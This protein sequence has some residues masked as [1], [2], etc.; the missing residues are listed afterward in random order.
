MLCHILQSLCTITKIKDGRNEVDLLSKSFLLP[1][2]LSLGLRDEP[3]GI[4]DPERSLVLG[5]GP[6]C[7][8]FD[9]VPCFQA[10]WDVGMLLCRHIDN[11]RSIS[12]DGPGHFQQQTNG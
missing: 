9:V 6:F 7:N 11:T 5:A 2:C 4:L 10:V 1:G 3:L 8:C 12:G